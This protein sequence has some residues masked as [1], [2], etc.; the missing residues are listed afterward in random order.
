MAEDEGFDPPQTESESGVLPLHKSSIFAERI[1]LYANIP[2]SQELF[3]DFSKIF[4]YIS[5]CSL[6]KSMHEVLNFPGEGFPFQNFIFE[7]PEGFPL[8]LVPEHG[9]EEVELPFR[10]GVHQLAVPASGEIVEG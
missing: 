4:F 1:L 8:A 5:I 7:I 2:K 9:Q 3:Q 6:G 10:L